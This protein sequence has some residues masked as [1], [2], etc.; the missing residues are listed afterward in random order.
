MQPLLLPGTRVLRR[1]ARHLQVGLDPDARVVLPDT[2][3]LRR[4]EGG[5]QLRR[6]PALAA[7]LAPVLL[8]DDAPLRSALPAHAPSYADPQAWSRHTVASLARRRRADAATLQRR[9]SYV[10]VVQPAVPRGEGRPPGLVHALA[11][12]LRLTCRR[13]G[14][15][16]AHA[17]PGGPRAH[18]PP[19]VR[20]LVSVGEPDRRVV[21][22]WDVPHLLVRFVEGHAV[23][24]PFVEPGTSACLRCADAH[25]AELDP[26]W[27]L[28]LEQYSRLGGAD[29]VDGVPEPVDAA[30]AAVSLGWAAR[31]LAS[32]VEGETPVS[33]GRTLRLDPSLVAIEAQDWPQRHDCGCVPV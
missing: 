33:T 29:R 8:P 13:S 27:P 3:E 17:V 7:R 22:S 21:D 26:A 25:L 30:L 9:S 6:D 11:D 15:R 24:G 1:D 18:R 12:E 2:P 4:L 16:V 5:E 32:Y 14:L 28:L 23:V 20:A 19:V 10:V 31:D